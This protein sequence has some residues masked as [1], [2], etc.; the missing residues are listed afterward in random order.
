M[1]KEDYMKDRVED[2][3]NWYEKKSA[4]NKKSYHRIKVAEIILAVLLP[5]ISGLHDFY[6]L[7]IATVAGFIGMMI[8]IISG[9]SVLYKYHDKWIEYRTTVESLKHEQY[10]FLTESGGYNSNDAF[11]IFVERFESLISK[12]NSNWAEIIKKQEDE[13]K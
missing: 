8:A 11:T 10:L 13:V 12:E 2:Q 6:G 5:F 9:I 1:N 4:K 7:E 3:I